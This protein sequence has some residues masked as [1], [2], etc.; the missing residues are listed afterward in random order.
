[1]EVPRIQNGE[2]TGLV[3]IIKKLLGDSNAVV[4]QLAVKVCGS[5]AKGLR[6]EFEPHCRELIG[7]LLQKFKEKKT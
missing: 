4:N 7:T 1:M 2:F 3:K 6:K 5:L